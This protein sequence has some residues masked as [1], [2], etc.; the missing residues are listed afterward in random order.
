MALMA[1]DYLCIVK[2]ASL[3]ISVLEGFHMTSVIKR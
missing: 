2:D 1:P 3:H